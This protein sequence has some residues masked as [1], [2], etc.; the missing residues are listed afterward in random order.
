[1]TV[2]VPV[3]VNVSID[4]DDSDLCGRFCDFI[5]DCDS[6]PHARCVL[7][8][9]RL[10]DAIGYDYGYLRCKDCKNAQKQVR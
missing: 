6:Q 7:F 3:L 1:M 10:S 8:E 5:D 9:V 2:Q 4:G